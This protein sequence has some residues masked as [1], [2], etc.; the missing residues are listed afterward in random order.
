MA[1]GVFDLGCCWLR[2]RKM[3][4]R[5]ATEADVKAAAE[6]Y[7]SARRFMKENGNPHQWSG[8]YPN[9]YDVREGLKDG[10]SYVCEDG[11]EIVATFYY[12]QNADDA[13]YHRIYE[14][15]WLS[16]APYS[17]I[18]RIAVK[19]HGRGIIDFCFEE[20]FKRFPSIRIDTHE[21]NIPMQ[22][23]LSRC[24]FKYCG[25]IYLADGAKR[26]AYQKID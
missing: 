1:L 20:C 8:D 18:H 3:I 7:E 15:E 10:T 25:I 4:I 26:L 14:G 11:G 12:K 9:E 6:I 17:V 24:G 23:C 13:T 22:K 16:D 19:Y 2:R 21:D 5:K